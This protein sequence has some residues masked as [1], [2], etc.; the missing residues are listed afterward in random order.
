MTQERV[1]DPEIINAL[2]PNEAKIEVKFLGREKYKIL[3][4]HKPP[5]SGT[6]RYESFEIAFTDVEDVDD[7]PDVI[8]NKWEELKV[9]H[10]RSSHET[11]TLEGIVK[12]FIKGFGEQALEDN[13]WETAINA[14][15]VITKGGV[16]NDSQTMEKLSEVIFNLSDIFYSPSSVIAS[17]IQNRKDL[18]L[19]IP[20]STSI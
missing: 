8:W 13:D 15:D 9:K 5:L 14:S 2:N 19:E 18:R 1:I 10:K 11:E 17:H 16:L 12:N 6:F 7:I 3:A 20:N 4:G